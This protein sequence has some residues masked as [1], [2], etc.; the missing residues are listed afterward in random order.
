MKFRGLIFANLFRKKTRL[1]LT[2]GS[3]AVALF[4]FGL[5][6]V[7]REAFSGGVDLAGADRLVV[8]NKTSIIQP[9]PLAYRDRILAMKGVKD[10]TFSN[11]FGGIYQDERNFFP[12]FAI[13]VHHQRTVFSEVAVA[14]DEWQKFVQDRQGAIVGASTAKKYGWKV[15]DRIP[16]KGTIFA[17][18]WDFNIDGIYHAADESQFWFQWDYLEERMPDRLK[19]Q[20]GWYTVKIN[21][22]EDTARLSKAIDNEFANSPYET[23]TDSEKTFAAN[24]LKQ[25]GNIQLLIMSI[26]SVVFFTLLLVTGNTM[27]IAVRERTGE[28]AVLKAV[29]YSDRFV[30]LLVLAESLVISAVGGL[31]GLLLAR[32]LIL[33][34]DPTHGLLP[35]YRM[36]PAVIPVGLG[37]ALAV[38]V[39]SGI[40]PA[41]GAMQLRVV[42]A[43][44]RV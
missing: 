38:G 9:L 30:L 11:W 35:I 41:I 31:L 19:G 33:L 8:I 44:R 10:I 28:L 39:A 29:G 43:L 12:Q 36:P 37:V 27:A 2:L 18:V 14:D 34:G 24:W 3:F 15:G 23:H 22:P 25:F 1:V 21:N 4:L 40:I 16:I 26:G 13:D 5:L 20:V 32:G 42:D 6:A 17:G 7:I